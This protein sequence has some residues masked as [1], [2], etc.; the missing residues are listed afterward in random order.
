[1]TG[2]CVTGVAYHARRRVYPGGSMI[3]RP[4]VAEDEAY[5][6]TMLNI[7]DPI[8]LPK[9]VV[10]AY[11]VFRGFL[12]RIGHGGLSP[13]MLAVLC[14]ISNLRVPNK[15]GAKAIEDIKKG[16]VRVDDTII[17]VWRDEFVEALFKALKPNGT[18]EAVLKNDETPIVRE[19]DPFDVE[20]VDNSL[21]AS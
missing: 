14:W 20:V 18:I 7:R 4:M 5:L 21:Q 1:M 19:F 15:V 12:D 13:E 9:V 8:P 10:D 11:W 16:L 17:V 2:A 6:R 3:P